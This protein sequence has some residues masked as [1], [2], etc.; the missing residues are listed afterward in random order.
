MVSE[1]KTPLHA[2]AIKAKALEFGADIVGIA[3][4]LAMEAFPPDPG[5]PRR[6]S[7]ITDLDGERVIVIGKKLVAG[8]SRLTRWDER[9][10]YYNDELTLTAL[11]DTSLDIVYWLEDNGYPAVV[12]PPTHVDPWRYQG[13]PGDHMST[14]LSLNHAAV[15]AGLGTLGLNLQLLT[16]EFGPRLMISAVLTSANCEADNL[17]TEALCHGPECGRCLRACPGDVIGHWQ[18]DWSACDRYRSPHGFAQLTE[19]LRKIFDTP[20]MGERMSLLRSEDSFNLWQ[21]ILRGS[22]VIT[23]CRR[24]QEVCPVGADYA[25]LE[26]AQAEI[27]EDNGEKDARL[28]EMAITEAEGELPA[29]YGQQ[30]RWIGTLAGGSDEGI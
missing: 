19:H 30:S 4:G 11:E 3:D 25:A 7:D 27:P 18:R 20:D 24:C 14:L 1:F 15:E 23:G 8:T 16:P 29:T 13:D 28:S 5:D 6:P 21:S 22:G 12:I 17:M 26:D 9:H 2:A 10:K